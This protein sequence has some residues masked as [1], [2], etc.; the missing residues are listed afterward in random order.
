VESLDEEAR[1]SGL[2]I[3]QATQLTISRC[4]KKDPTSPGWIQRGLLEL[5][6]TGAGAGVGIGVSLAFSFFA[7]DRDRL[8]VGVGTGRV[9][10]SSSTS[11]FF[12]LKVAFPF[13][14]PPLASDSSSA[15]TAGP[16]LRALGVFVRSTASVVAS[17]SSSKRVRVVDASEFLR[18]L[19]FPPFVLDSPLR[20]EGPATGG[21]SGGGNASS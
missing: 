5:P 14:F 6:G 4:S 3:F 1:I 8:A 20:F 7:G 18:D 12:S 11:F 2:L 19:R 13:P 10:F 16:V 15:P 9:S 21:S 17:S